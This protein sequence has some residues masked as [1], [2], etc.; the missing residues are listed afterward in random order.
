MKKYAAS[1]LTAAFSFGM[2]VSAFALGETGT[3]VLYKMTHRTQAGALVTYVA[4]NIAATDDN[5]YWLQ[6][7]AL[8][9][10]TSA[11]LSITQTRLD[12]ETHQPQRYIMHRP[13]NMD[14]PANVIDLPLAKMGKD[15]ILPAQ[16][17]SG[18][19]Q[20]TT[21]AGTFSA[22]EVA[23]E[24]ATLSVSADVPVLGVVKA[25]SDEWTMELVS[26]SDTAA[27]LLPKKPDKGGIVYLNEE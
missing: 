1:F 16:A 14:H 20:V 17:E 25:E 18:D 12:A 7:V 22:K 4:Y 9:T 27:D 3:T 15:E 5:G 2:A 13:A 26:M 6:R 23:S 8:M 21:E 10:P 24:H 19:V 11:P